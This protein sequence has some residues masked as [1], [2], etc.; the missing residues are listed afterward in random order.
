[1]TSDLRKEG[2]L[3]QKQMIVLVGSMNVTRVRGKY[4]KREIL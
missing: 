3:A 2:V 1:M 4:N